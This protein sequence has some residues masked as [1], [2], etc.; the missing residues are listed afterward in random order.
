MRI[1]ALGGSLVLFPPS[2]YCRWWFGL[3]GINHEE[4]GELNIYH[5]YSW[6]FPTSTFLLLPSLALPISHLTFHSTFHR[7][8]PEHMLLFSHP[9]NDD[10]SYALGIFYIPDDNARVEFIPY[11]VYADFHWLLMVS[12]VSFLRLCS[13]IWIW[14]FTTALVSGLPLCHECYI[15]RPN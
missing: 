7:I 10:C 1:S 8:Q 9:S 6:L 2:K 12:L 5:S 14:T 15:G 4:T 3:L 11:L 13:K